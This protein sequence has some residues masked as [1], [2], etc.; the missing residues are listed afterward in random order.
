MDIKYVNLSQIKPAEY[1]PRKITQKQIDTL[2]ESVKS[3]G[4]AIPIIVNNKNNIIIAGHQRTKA[5]HQLGYTKVPVIY[6]DGI[7]KTDEI[8]LNQLHNGVTDKSSSAEL[9]S[10]NQYPKNRFI[11]ILNSEFR[12]ESRQASVVK[13]SCNIIVKYGNILSAVVCK[14][15][16]MAGTEYVKACQL[17]NQK[18]NCYILED[19]KYN[20]A[21]YYLNQGYGKYCYQRANKKTYVQGLA[22]LSRSTK[23]SDNKKQYRSVLYEDNVLPYLKQHNVQT[24]LDFGCGKGAYISKLRN[25]YSNALGVEFYNHSDGKINI[26]KGNAQID[27]LIQY[28][29]KRKTF[30]VVICDSVLN[31][32][33]SIEAEQSVVDC[34]NLF[35][36]DILFISGRPISNLIKNACNNQ[37]TTPKRNIQFLDEN[38]FTAYLRC[39]EWYYQHYHT[40]D[41]VEQ[42]LNESGFVI[43]KY[44]ASSSSF[45][46]IAIKKQQLSAE[47]Y[48]KAVEFEFNLPLP[49][50]R[51]YNRADEIKAVLGLV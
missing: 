22:Q 20:D 3:L 25:T 34:L 47:R 50:D 31:S 2:S 18:V 44:V 1:N 49:N 15:K 37:D 6:V 38:N 35:C 14:N 7:T 9:L 12:V 26:S 33:D 51:S 46:I 8:K 27:E 36:Q 5:A 28:L 32:V 11:E 13:E 23:K 30:D 29:K 43:K 17:L 42:L 19:S 24:I 39:G 21:L 4:I 10:K 48:R 40:R 41:T 16:V 45:Q